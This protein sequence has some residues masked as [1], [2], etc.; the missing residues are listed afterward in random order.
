MDSASLFDRFSLLLRVVLF[1]SVAAGAFGTSATADPV[2]IGITGGSASIE[3]ESIDEF[4][5]HALLTGPQGFSVS[6]GAFGLF[7]AFG[8]EFAPPGLVVP[9][10]G[11][12]PLHGGS[13]TYLGVEYPFRSDSPPFGGGSV[14]VRGGSFTLPEIPPAEPLVIRRPV[15]MSGMV[16]VEDYSHEGPPGL[17][18]FYLS[19]YGTATLEVGWIRDDD[20][21]VY[22][23]PRSMA[24][25]FSPAPV[26]EPA[27][28]LLVVGGLGA[29]WLQ[30]SRRTRREG[31]R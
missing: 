3:R 25:D 15:V 31:A 12:V 4:N 29:T 30:R 24:V 14:D 18:Q 20:G 2:V 16:H 1:T 10:S 26:P 21:A 27:S 19:G 17:L 13:L 7:G 5:A 22:Y 9:F 6:G 11:S 28:V 23:L 8:W